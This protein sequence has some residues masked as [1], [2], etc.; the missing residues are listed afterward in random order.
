MHYYRVYTDSQ[1]PQLLMARSAQ[2]AAAC[3]QDGERV[4][5]EV[6]RL[7]GEEMTIIADLLAGVV[8][9]ERENF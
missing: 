4:R 3:H 2:D 1:P 9:M 8:E 7:T 6:A 5:I